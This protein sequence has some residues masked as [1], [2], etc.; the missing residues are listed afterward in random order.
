MLVATVLF[1]FFAAVLCGIFSGTAAFDGVLTSAAAETVTF[2]LSIGGSVCFFC[3]IAEVAKASGLISKLGK[4]SEPI[5]KKIMPKAFCDKETSFAAVTNLVSNFFGLG[6][7]ATPFGIKAASK[8]SKGGVG[9]SLALFI[10]LN[11]S[12]LQLIPSTVISIRQS[13]GS[14]DPTSVILPVFITQAVSAVFA[15][16]IS[17][18]FF[19]EDK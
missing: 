2:I 8:M 11:T 1:L 18:V 3:G 6:N 4:I 14:S 12:S 13:A 7:A 9:R 19:K 16:L 17:L 5:L 10:F 15:V